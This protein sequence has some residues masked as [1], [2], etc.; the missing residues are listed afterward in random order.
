MHNKANCKATCF[1]TNTY[2]NSRPYVYQK[3]PPNTKLNPK[4]KIY[5]LCFRQPK[6]IDIIDSDDEDRDKLK[7][8]NVLNKYNLRTK[9]TGED[10]KIDLEIAI[11]VYFL[12]LVIQNDL[13]IG[14][15]LTFQQT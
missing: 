8:N 15:Q 13:F 9:L 3:P 10:G 5:V 14:V 7:G 11:I 2:K 12:T 6:E 4:D 1:Q